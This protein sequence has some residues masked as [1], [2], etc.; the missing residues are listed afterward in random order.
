MSFLY[1]F[2]HKIAQL[3]FKKNDKTQMF[4]NCDTIPFLASQKNVLAK[5]GDFDENVQKSNQSIPSIS[6]TLKKP[7]LIGKIVKSV[8]STKEASVSNNSL[9]AM[10]IDEEESNGDS[11]GSSSTDYPLVRT[12]KNKGKKR[13]RKSITH[14]VCF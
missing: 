1:K 4:Y 3:A 12:K 5:G 2:R 13:K 7:K 6:L 11:D 14:N 9:N 10:E 8:G